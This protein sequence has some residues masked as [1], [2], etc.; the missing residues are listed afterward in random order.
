MSRLDRHL[1]AQVLELT[2]ITALA[3]MAIQAFI[4]FAA[5]A[6]DVGGGFGFVELALY[7]VML[8]PSALLTMLPMIALLGTLLGLGT[9]ASQGEL[10]AMRAVGV[11]VLRFG[12]AV[13]LAGLVLGALALVLG[14][15][16]GPAGQ[17]A[18][19]RLRDVAKHG[20]DPDAAAGPVWLRQGSNLIHIRSLLGE[21]HV[22][23]VTAYN[24]DD[25]FRLQSVSH[26]ER[27][28]HEAGRWQLSGIARSVFEQGR[29]RAEHI[30]AADWS[31]EELP[32]DV[33]RLFVLEAKSLSINGLIRLIEFMDANGLD[34]SGYRLS[35]WRKLV[36]PLGVVVM[37]LLAIPFV[38]GPL[39]DTGA[40]QRLLVGVLVGLLY[41]IASEVVANTGQLYDWPPLLSASLPTLL[42]GGVA[43]W[44]MA[45]FR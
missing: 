6:G 14:D 31:S 38:L 26:I 13:M 5:E 27:A 30:E 35:L 44:R 4:T 45:R 1:M 9:L 19:Q 2:A 29:V 15:W 32:P 41:W 28:R 17:H 24:L 42:V 11:S 22:A 10:V 7:V 40:G 33:L 21:D 43:I 36:A 25:S 23:D 16:L 3:L 20:V 34:S 37:M 18:A 8:V 39:R 12:R